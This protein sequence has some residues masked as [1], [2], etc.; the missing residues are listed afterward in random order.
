MKHKSLKTLLLS[1]L[2]FLALILTNQVMAQGTNTA[3]KPING[4]QVTL[5]KNDPQSGLV[6]SQ[7]LSN[8][9]IVIDN[10]GTVK[11]TNETGQEVVISK[12]ATVVTSADAD[13]WANYPQWEQGFKAWMLANPNFENYLT[14]DEMNYWSQG[15]AMGIY[16]LNYK[17][18]LNS[19]TRNQL[20]QA[21]NE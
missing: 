17:Q 20:N 14:S 4:D 18:S 5:A 9:A 13:M 2:M 19:F 3:E 11:M 21:N 1:G 16:K 10:N 8:G 15:D 7:M 12:P 6:K